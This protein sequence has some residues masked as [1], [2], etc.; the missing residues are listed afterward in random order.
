MMR[1]DF[2]SQG[3]LLQACSPFELPPRWATLRLGSSSRRQLTVN[4]LI[5]PPPRGRG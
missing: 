1:A 3:G 4:A 2:D 5:R